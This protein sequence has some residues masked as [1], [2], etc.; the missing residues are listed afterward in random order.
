MFGNKVDKIAKLAQKGD[1]EKLVEFITDKKDEVRLAAIDA[2]GQCSGD[3]P[4]NALVPL[5]HTGDAQTRIHAANALANMKQPRARTFIEHQRAMER[6]PAVIKALD[7]ALASI[8]DD[9]N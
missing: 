7:D 2:L 6:D 8:K 4:F 1:G 3:V 9:E 5:V